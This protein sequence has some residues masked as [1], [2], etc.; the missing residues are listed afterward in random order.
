MVYMRSEML[1]RFCGRMYLMR[2]ASTQYSSC[3]SIEAVH[4][5]M[6]L[7]KFTSGDSPTPCHPFDIVSP[8]LFG[9]IRQ[10]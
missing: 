5:S 6:R 7:C 9:A 4:N 1:N 8:A 3:A 2:S 10:I